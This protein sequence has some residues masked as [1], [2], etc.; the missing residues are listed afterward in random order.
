[1]IPRETDP[2]LVGAITSSIEK[3]EFVLAA[4]HMPRGAFSFHNLIFFL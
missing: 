3:F 1:M 4:I 2:A